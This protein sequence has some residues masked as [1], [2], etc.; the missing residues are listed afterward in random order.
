MVNVINRAIT[1][2]ITSLIVRS[3]LR[4]WDAI[5]TRNKMHIVD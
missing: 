5:N 2:P 1:E 3:R 4:V